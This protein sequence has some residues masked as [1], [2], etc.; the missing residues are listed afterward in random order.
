MKII[1]VNVKTEDGKDNSNTSIV[2]E[3]DRG[4]GYVR[5]DGK[6]FVTNKDKE[7]SFRL[8]QGERLVIEAYAPEAVAYDRAQGAAYKTANQRDPSKMDSSVRG[9]NNDAPSD[10]EKALVKQ[11][12]DRKKAADQRGKQEVQQGQ[13]KSDVHSASQSIKPG[14]ATPSGVKPP[15]PQ[16]SVSIGAGSGVKAPASPQQ[17]SGGISQNPNSGVNK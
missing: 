2:I 10:A 12:E 1:T 11:E 17:G 4:A 7:Q 5:I 15:S 13:Q 9:A 14:V 8:R 16:D 6:D 3:K